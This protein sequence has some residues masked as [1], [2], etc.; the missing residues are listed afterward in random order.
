[1]SKDY[2]ALPEVDQFWDHAA[3]YAKT[4]QDEAFVNEIA[5]LMVTLYKTGT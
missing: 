2:K 1:M 3:I 5:Y 4:G